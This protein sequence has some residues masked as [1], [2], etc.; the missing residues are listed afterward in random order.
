MRI[1]DEI[2]ADIT[3]VLSHLLCP[4]NLYS[5]SNI[6]FYWNHNVK[7]SAHARAQGTAL[8]MAGIINNSYK[9]RHSAWG[10]VK[11]S[12]SSS[13]DSAGKEPE[14]VIES[15]LV[16]G[17]V[18]TEGTTTSQLVAG[19]IET[20]SDQ[21][22]RLNVSQYG[23]WFLFFKTCVCVCVCVCMCVWCV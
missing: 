10:P 7:L 1:A 3:A 20:L 19:N 9:K 16:A 5:Y 2:K 22:E 12:M 14:G 18:G 17:N 13:E 6:Y 8:H 4:L 11:Q 23:K 15:R 21:L